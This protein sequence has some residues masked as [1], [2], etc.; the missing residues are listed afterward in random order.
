M[1]TLPKKSFSV[2]I[3]NA[4]PLLWDLVRPRLGLLVLGLLLGCTVNYSH[5]V[6]GS[7]LSTVL[8]QVTIIGILGI[9]QTLVILTAGIDL[10]VGVIMV[11]LAAYIWLVFPGRRIQLLLAFA[12]GIAPSLL[13]LGWYN[14][15]AFGSPFHL[16]YAYVADEAF[17]C[18]SGYEI[19][20]IVSID[21]FPLGDGKVGPITQRLTRA[22]MDI[23]HG[24]DSRF[25]EWRTPTY[26]PVRV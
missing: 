7:N 15:F 1:A 23:V 2:R 25:P 3:R 9:A 18:G 4:W 19:T 26:R 11:I 22:Y 16:S 12:A 20:P 21:K 10:S 13:L 5:F 6:T 17:F 14:W 8:T 24:V